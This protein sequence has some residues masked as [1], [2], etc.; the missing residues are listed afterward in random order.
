MIIGNGLI[1]NAFIPY[2]GNDSDILVFAS[3]VS[4]SRQN[5]SEAFL[6]ERRMLLDALSQQQHVL[7]FSTCSI[8]DP[9]LR[10][11]PYVM[12][13]NEMETLV[14]SVKNYTIFRLPQVVGKTSNP[15]TLTNYLYQHVES[16]KSFEV[17][18]HAQ[19]YLIDVDDVASIVHFLIKS[20][21][22]NGITLNVASLFS[23]SI[24]QL[25]S[26]FEL[27][28]NRKAN[29]TLV[30]DGGAYLIESK[31]A[32]KAAANLGINFENGYI[33]NIIRKYYENIEPV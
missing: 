6:R 13:K 9:Q 1:A 16:G 2:F 8:E 4:N 29:Y 17:W 28:L 18:R 12:H 15:N 31:L 10:N 20:S 23:I 3:G 25:V 22:A 27:L 19:R 7:Y 30:E 26:I 32:Q 11:T 33:E 5:L 21:Q 14:R 24:H